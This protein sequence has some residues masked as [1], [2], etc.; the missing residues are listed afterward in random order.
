MTS[1]TPLWGS[2]RTI[3]DLNIL[4]KYAYTCTQG[5]AYFEYD[6]PVVLDLFVTY[7]YRA[8]GDEFSINSR[9]IRGDGERPILENIEKRSRNDGSRELFP[10]LHNPHRKGRF[11]QLT[12]NITLMNRVGASS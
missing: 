11:S 4:S 7:E 3:A 5:T 9:I 1:L 12:M 8:W 6:D 10:L 2:F